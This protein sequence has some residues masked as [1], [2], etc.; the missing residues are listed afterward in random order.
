M[1]KIACGNMQY[2]VFIHKNSLVS[3]NSDLMNKQGAIRG[4]FQTPVFPRYK[5]KHSTCHFLKLPDWYFF[6]HCTHVLKPSIMTSL[7][8]LKGKKKKK[9]SSI[10]TAASEGA[11]IAF[12]PT[13]SPL[14]I[15]LYPFI[16]LLTQT[17]HLCTNTVFQKNTK[18][19]AVNS[20][21]YCTKQHGM[22]DT[23]RCGTL[24]VSLCKCLY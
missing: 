18:G 23:A 9:Q 20:R 1:T 14:F 12:K 15:F 16:K 22:T 5:N 13:C 8:N 6:L 7:C 19:V 17:S 21:K 10:E 2:C 3:F 4:T 11:S 24:R